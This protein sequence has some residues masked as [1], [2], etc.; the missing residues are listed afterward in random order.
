MNRYSERQRVFFRGTSSE[1]LT[2]ILDSQVWESFCSCFLFMLLCLAWEK[3]VLA[4]SIKPVTSYWARLDCQPLF[5]EMS[6]R[7][8]P[9]NRESGGNRAYH[10]ASKLKS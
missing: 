9:E 2:A 10:W 8:L 3:F 4:L 5:R 1:D 6:P 7:S